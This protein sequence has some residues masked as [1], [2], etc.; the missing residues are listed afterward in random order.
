MKNIHHILYIYIY[1]PADLNEPIFEEFQLHIHT[2]KLGKLF[3]EQNKTFG[4]LN[5]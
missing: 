1:I 5:A 2:D 4:F 3:S